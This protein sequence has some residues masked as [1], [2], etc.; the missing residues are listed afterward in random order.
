VSL[1]PVFLNE[2]AFVHLPYDAVDPN[3]IFRLSES[4]EYPNLYEGGTPAVVSR[5]EFQENFEI[6]TE[7]QLRFVNWDNVV[8]SGGR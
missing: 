7:G 8:V 1:V 2:E 5:S 4:M 3:L 6:F